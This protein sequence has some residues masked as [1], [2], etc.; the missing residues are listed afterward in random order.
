MPVG[1]LVRTGLVGGIATLF[2]ALT[3]L[4]AKVAEINLIGTQVT[5]ARVMMAL[6]PFI[7]AYV[8]VRPRVVAGQ[9]QTATTSDAAVSGA[10]AGVASGGLVAVALLF[11]DWYGVDRVGEIFIQVN[12]D[13]MEILAFGT[14]IAVGAV[15]PDGRRGAAGSGRRSVPDPRA[16]P[17]TAD[18][19]RRSAS[20][21]SPGCCSGSSRSP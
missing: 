10:I 17:A 3:G 1:R 8:A 18:R 9:I 12:D 15:D 11:A 5:G 16:G 21:C 13:L 14:N 19:R 2:V 7:A 4:L 6:S 20:R